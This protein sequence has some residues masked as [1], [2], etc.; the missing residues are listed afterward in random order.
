MIDPTTDRLG[1]HF[2]ADR[3]FFQGQGFA[4]VCESSGWVW[5]EEKYTTRS[6]LIAMLVETMNP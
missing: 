4:V 6:E 3:P 1:V 2:E 5:H